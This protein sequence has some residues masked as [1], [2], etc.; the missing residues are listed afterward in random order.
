MNIEIKEFSFFGYFN[1]KLII[2]VI[3]VFIFSTNSKNSFCP[4]LFFHLRQSIYAEFLVLHIF[5][6][7]SNNNFY[8]ILKRKVK[9][10]PFVILIENLLF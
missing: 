4:I 7:I 8:F 3:D 6:S 5:F 9:N 1:R 2:V 10:F